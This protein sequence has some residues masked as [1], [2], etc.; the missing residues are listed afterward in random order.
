MR[1]GNTAAPVLPQAKSHTHGS[2]AEAVVETEFHLQYAHN[3]RADKAADIDGGVKNRKTGVAQITR[4]FRFIQ[5]THH[6]T[7]GRFHPAAAQS[8]Q[9]QAYHQTAHIGKCG[10][11]NVPQH[12]HYARQE[13]RFF[14]A[15]DA[16]RQPTAQN[17]GQIDTAVIR[18]HDAGGLGFIH[19]QTTLGNLIIQINQQDGLHAVERKTFPQLDVE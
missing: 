19:A 15:Q 7:G 3:Q 5:R 14:R 6:R 13:Q 1:Q 12:H 16:V 10:Q 11:Y 17:G 2:S 18:A 4:G 8:N 9:Q